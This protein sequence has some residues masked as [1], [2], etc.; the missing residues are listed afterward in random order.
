MGLPELGYA[1][2]GGRLSIFVCN[3]EEYA[4]VTGSVTVVV[5][6]PLPASALDFSFT[7]CISRETEIAGG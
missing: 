1:K 6:I 3:D 7:T 5:Q 4:I 2:L